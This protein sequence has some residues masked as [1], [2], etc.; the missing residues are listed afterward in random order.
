[1]CRRHCVVAVLV[2]GLGSLR[3]GLPHF[4]G[5]P[6]AMTRGRGARGPNCSPPCHCERSEAIPCVMIGMCIATLL[7]GD[8][9]DGLFLG[10]H[11]VAAALAGD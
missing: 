7:R 3:K 1:M 4:A 2:C 8:G 5:A 11:S 9:D 6:F 10:R